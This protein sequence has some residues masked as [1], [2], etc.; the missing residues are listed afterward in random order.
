MG[1]AAILSPSLNPGKWVRARYLNVTANFIRPNGYCGCCVCRSMNIRPCWLNVITPAAPIVRIA[2]TGWL[3]TWNTQGWNTCNYR[4]EYAGL[5]TQP[6]VTSTAF[7]SVQAANVVMSSPL[8]QTW[9]PSA[10][11]SLRSL[12]LS[13]IPNRCC[14]PAPWA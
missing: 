3:K 9:P 7:C 5:S 1:G 13:G 11:L 12:S 8:T 6:I 14:R 4:I 2:G 10:A